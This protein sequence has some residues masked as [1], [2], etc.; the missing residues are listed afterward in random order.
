MRELDKDLGKI[1][2][3]DDF[4]YLEKIYEYLSE[5]IRE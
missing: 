5:L 2:N 3:K 1:Y 4:Y